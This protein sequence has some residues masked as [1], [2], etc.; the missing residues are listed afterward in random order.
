MQFSGEGYI[1][2]LRN[3]GEKSLIATLVCPEHGKI[4]GFIN[5][6]HSKRGLGVYQL[7]N[8]ISFNAYARVAENMLSLKGVELVE[9][10]TADFMLNTDKI[11][12]LSSLCRLL[13]VCVAE[14][15]NLGRF[16]KEVKDFFKHINDDNWL[17]Y[18]SYFEYYL[19]DFLGVGLDISECAVTGKTEGLSYVSP[20]TGR[21]VCEEIGAPY[22]DKL[23]AYPQYIVDKNY[24]PKRA[25]V[26]NLLA[27]TGGF[28][29]KNFLAGHNLQLPEKR[30]NLLNI[31]KKY[32]I[33]I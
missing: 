22:K 20:K 6:A 28:L 30:A 11:E 17:V 16:Y 2:K 25:E 3:Q 23:Y 5:G 31:V 12:A 10:H 15:D 19:L 9:A 33:K 24:R 8:Y 18:Y 21:A 27:M 32:Q 7:G 13:D 14:N 26:A 1:I 4:V 29:T